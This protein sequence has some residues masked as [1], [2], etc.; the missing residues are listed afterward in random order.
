MAFE[1]KGSQPFNANPDTGRMGFRYEW[2]PVDG[3][4]CI[5]YT[6]P[7]WRDRFEEAT[8]AAAVAGNPRRPDEGPFAYIRRISE[9]VTQEW[10]AGAKTMPHVRMSR[11]E[12]DRELAKLRD[13]AKAL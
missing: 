8:Y 3:R 10:E 11:R 6:E 13:Q 5:V 1:R 4:P 12:R 7:F 2:E 9:L